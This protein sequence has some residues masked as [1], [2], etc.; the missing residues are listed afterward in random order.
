MSFVDLPV[1]VIPQVKKTTIEVIFI[2][3]S[4]EYHN[5]NHHHHSKTPTVISTSTST[6][7]ASST[8]P[9][10]PLSQ[11]HQYHDKA[12]FFIILAYFPQ[13]SFVFLFQTYNTPTLTE[14]KTCIHIAF[15][16]FWN[17][18]EKHDRVGKFKTDGKK[19]N[20]TI[21]TWTG[22]SDDFVTCE[23]LLCSLED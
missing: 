7:T 18:L 14:Q 5:P 15:V 4:C 1:K 20:V 21:K 23:N 6:A 13:T 3:H 10:P 17:T 9:Q 2:F 11:T 8:N 22:L 16:A 19:H 12:C